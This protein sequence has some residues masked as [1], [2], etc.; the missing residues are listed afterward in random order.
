MYMVHFTNG[1]LMQAF[2]RVLSAIAILTLTVTGTALGQGLGAEGDAFTYQFFEP[3]EPSMRV[4]IWGDVGNA[5]IWRV[6]RD[7]NFVEL[8][9]AARPGG[10]GQERARRRQRVSI[11][12]YRVI[13][14]ERRMIYEEPLSDMLEE[15]LRLPDL[16]GEDVVEVRTREQRGR[17]EQFRLVTGLIGSSASL[18]LLFL[19]LTGNQ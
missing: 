12:V 3:G 4:Y 14:G 16:E 19:R 8:L 2:Q 9:S 6:S 13:E 18:V 7:V 11:H 15:G 10:V 1:M 17:L 5:G